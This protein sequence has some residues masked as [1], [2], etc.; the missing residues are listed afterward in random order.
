MSTR[1]SP[2]VKQLVIVAGLI[3]ATWLLFRGRVVL[4]PLVLALLLAVLAS[5]PANWLVRRTGWSRSLVAGLILLLVLLLL[6]AISVLVVPWLVS[7][8]RALGGTL[9]NVIQQLLEVEPRPVEITPTLTVDLG[10]F[11]EPI[12]EWLRSLLSPNLDTLQNLQ[13]L[14]FPFATGAATVVIG[15]A[16][17]A[18]WLLFIL[19]VS[20]YVIRDLPRLYRAVAASVPEA[21]RPEIRSLWRELEAV[22]DAF[23]RGRLLLSLMMGLIVWAMLSLL[24]VRN[25]PALGFLHGLLSFVPAVGPVVAAIPGILI[26]LILGS[27]WLP[28]PNI[29]F[30]VLVTAFYL[31]LEQLDN[32]FLLPRIVGRR[33]A[34]HPAIVIVG[35]VVGAE[36]AGVLGI[37]LAAPVIASLRVLGLYALRKLFDQEP[38][39][40]VR[41][42]R[43]REVLWG[44][45]LQERSVQGV[46]FDLDGTLIETDDALV[47]ALADRLGR[48]GR[49]LS[50]AERER[51]ARR[52]V[53][54]SESFVNGLL[55]L[56]DRLHLDGLLFRL[57]EASLRWRGLAAPRR[58]TA[59]AGTAEALR[60]LT[61]KGYR[62][63]IVTTRSRRDAEAYLR[64]FALDGLFG[65]VVTRDDVR[66]LKPHPAPVR[67]AAR[68]L[69]LEPAQ[70]I[71]VGDTGVDVRAATAAGALAVGVLCGFGLR[72]DLEE[73]NL[74]LDSTA[75]LADWL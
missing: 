49:L 75:Q 17:G 60:A 70:C 33:V 43:R 64:Q 62:L 18:V 4:G 3:V 59:V 15:A 7:L 10:H 69:G 31:V 26:A 74:V 25:A 28:L 73:A 5:Y 56:L 48:F 14:I 32:L 37:L 46:L 67:E 53:M 38:F 27:T 52:V 45:L 22:W 57:D 8:L 50:A 13:R 47:R 34:L 68:A 40:P 16:S 58:F 24:G 66:R 19:V 6:G 54:N 71:V 30:A 41:R 2:F 36:L 21:W 61:G 12:N 72:N 51:F 42:P 55:T 35:V 44:E 11:Y 39:P 29:W 63:G 20:F 9:V 65:A 1:W 23:V